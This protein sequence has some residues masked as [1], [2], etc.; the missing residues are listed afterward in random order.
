MYFI[1]F[2]EEITDIIDG[3]DKLETSYIKDETVSTQSMFMGRIFEVTNSVCSGLRK[4][5]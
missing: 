2:S 5:P 3:T 4:I 1:N